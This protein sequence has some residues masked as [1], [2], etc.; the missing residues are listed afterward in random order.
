M[1]RPSSCTSCLYFP[2]SWE[3]S[4]GS[5][6]SPLSLSLGW[7]HL[8]CH[9]VGTVLWK[10]I[11]A[12]GLILQTPWKVH[13]TQEGR[14]HLKHQWSGCFHSTPGQSKLSRDALSCKCYCL[15]WTFKL[16]FWI[17]VKQLCT[18]ELQI[19]GSSLLIA[20]SNN[21]PLLIKSRGFSILAVQKLLKLKGKQ[22]TTIFSRLK[23]WFLVK[24]VAPEA[25][26][27][28]ETLRTSF[29]P[30]WNLWVVVVNYYFYKCLL[31]YKRMR[32]LPWPA[33]HSS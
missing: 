3:L 33:W 17:L 23:L 18:A 22:R 24:K 12:W 7:S 15:T 10:E 26:K 14:F 29:Q 1:I 8:S 5:P 32:H 20:F 31:P 13:V 6:P 27:E 11:L 9:L 21:L 16:I 30:D 4:E 2:V 25:K 28:R 19:S